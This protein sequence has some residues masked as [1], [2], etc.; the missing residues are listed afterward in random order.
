MKGL[1]MNKKSKK[2]YTD[3]LEPVFSKGHQFADRIFYDRKEGKYYDK[4][5]DIYLGLDEVKMLGLAQN[6]TVCL[7]NFLKG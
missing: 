1:N 5:T 7:E 3:D 4:Y 2:E 6:A